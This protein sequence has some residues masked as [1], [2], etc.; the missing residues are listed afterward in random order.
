MLLCML[1]M[2]WERRLEA[3]LRR[4]SLA[5]GSSGSVEDGECWPLFELESEVSGGVVKDLDFVS[6]A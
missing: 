5:E 6:S 4:E 3:A 2:R 1:S